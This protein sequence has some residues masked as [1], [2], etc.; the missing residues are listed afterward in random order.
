MT[1][2]LLLAYA[3]LRAMRLML[4]GAQ[5][6]TFKQKALDLWLHGLQ[7]EQALTEAAREVWRG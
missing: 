2:E 5:S 7:A 3:D 4:T 6:W 1:E